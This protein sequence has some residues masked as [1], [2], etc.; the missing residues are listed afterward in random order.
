ML[1]LQETGLDPSY[2][3]SNVSFSLYFNS[4]RTFSLRGWCIECDVSEVNETLFPKLLEGFPTP[5]SRSVKIE[6]WIES[7]T[8]LAEGVYTVI[9]A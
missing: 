4:N 9:S 1:Q 7:L 2:L 8:R 6:G 5:S 3:T